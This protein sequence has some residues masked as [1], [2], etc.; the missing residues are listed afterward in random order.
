[1]FYK[2]S[3]DDTQFHV[4]GLSSKRGSPKIYEIIK[5]LPLYST[6]RPIKEEKYCVSYIP[7]VYQERVKNLKN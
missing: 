3:L 2:T 7:P 6:P 1:M 4:V 5:L